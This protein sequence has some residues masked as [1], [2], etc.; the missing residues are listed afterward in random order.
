MSEFGENMARPIKN[1]VSDHFL[2]KKL[3]AETSHFFTT[4]RYLEDGDVVRMSGFAQGRGYR[5]LY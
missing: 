3:F 2:Q 1:G 5:V 4:R